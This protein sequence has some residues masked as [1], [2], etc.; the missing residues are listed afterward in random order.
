[1]Q[2]TWLHQQR[3]PGPG[4]SA[5]APQSGSGS[6][7]LAVRAGGPTVGHG[8]GF[9]QALHRSSTPVSLSGRLS[10]RRAAS[11]KEVELLEEVVA[12][13]QEALAATKEALAATKKASFLEIQGLRTELAL[14]RGILNMRGTMGAC[15]WNLW[16]ALPALPAACLHPACMQP[17]PQLA[18]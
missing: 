14:R 15:C 6:V 1:M 12:A 18:P 2:R 3:L 7:G 10:G 17:S 16:P 4:A 11:S 13:K 5:A 9:R 8:G